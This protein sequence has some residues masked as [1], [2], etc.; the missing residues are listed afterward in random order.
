MLTSLLPGIRERRTPLAAAYTLIVA[1]YVLI[2]E[3]FPRVLDNTTGLGRD[4]ARIS[5]WLKPGPTLA[6]TTFIA[7]LIGS[8]LSQYLG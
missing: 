7:F 2:S 1:I 6:G 3:K 8:R 5:Y 4:L